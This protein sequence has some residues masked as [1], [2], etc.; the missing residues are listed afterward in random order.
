[1]TSAGTAQTQGVDL[2]LRARWRGRV[3]GMVTAARS[4]SSYRALDGVR[5][6]GNYDTPGALNA[7]GSVRLPL[8][9]ELDLRESAASGRPYTPYDLADSNAQNRGIYDLSRINA[10]RLPFY[11]RLDIELERR[12][13]TPKGVVDVHAGAENILNRGNSM[14][15][16]W[17][18]NCRSDWPCAIHGEPEIKVDQMGRY[19]VFSARYEF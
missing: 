12:F 6:T 4:Q 9:I 17:L 5:R 3:E 14:G 1:M 11:N 2:T 13:R 8:G 15:S 16:V 19:P 18:D 7:S 10:L